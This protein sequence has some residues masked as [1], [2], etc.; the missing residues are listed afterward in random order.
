LTCFFAQDAPLKWPC[1]PRFKLAEFEL[2]PF[3]PIEVLPDASPGAAT[4][5]GVAVASGSR[6][7][8]IAM[9][10]QTT[11]RTDQQLGRSAVLGQT[12]S[13]AGTLSCV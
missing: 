5:D 2:P 4:V 13:F 6:I 1:D 9:M 8:T 10:R 7:E 11:F 3:L 12:R